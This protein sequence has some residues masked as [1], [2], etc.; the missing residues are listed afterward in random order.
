MFPV[1]RCRWSPYSGRHFTDDLTGNHVPQ[2]GPAWLCTCSGPLACSWSCWSPYQSTPKPVKATTRIRRPLQPGPRDA[3][4]SQITLGKETTWLQRPRFQ[5]PLSSRLRQLFHCTLY[6]VDHTMHHG[7]I[8]RIHW[9][10][11]RPGQMASR[12]TCMLRRWASVTV[13]T[14]AVPALVL[15]SMNVR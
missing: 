15:S 13:V 9:S 10:C 14:W 1:Y 11:L 6:A 12:L 8:H 4:S 7:V 3:I 5:G 2:V